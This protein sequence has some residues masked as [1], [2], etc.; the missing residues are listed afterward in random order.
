MSGG[1]AA[2]V[3]E[4]G[5]ASSNVKKEDKPPVPKEAKEAAGVPPAELPE[6]AR[7]IESYWIEEPFV[8]IDIAS[9]EEMGWAVGYFVREVKLN[10][11]EEKAYN[12]LVEILSKELSPPSDSSADATSH[13]LS[14]AR[15][16]IAKYRSF[17]G[18]G[19]KESER[20]VEY[21]VRRNLLGYGPVDP[22]VRDVNIEDISCDGLKRA[23]YVWHRKHESLFSNVMMTDAD[24]FDNFI[25][26]LAHL[27]GRHVSTAFPIVDAMLPG[28]H[29]LA[30]TYGREVSTGGSTFCIRKFREEPFSIVDLIQMGTLDLTM[31]AY[32]WLLLDLRLTLMIIGG[33]GAGKTSLLN[34]LTNLFKPGLKIVTVEETAELNIPHENWVQFVTRESYGLGAS[35]TGEVSLFELVRTSLRYRPDYIIVGEVRGDEAFVLFQAMASVSGDTPV[36]V[37]SDKGIELTE[38]RKLVDGYYADGE[39]RIGKPVRGLQVL[40]LEGRDATFKPVRYVLR[41]SADDIFKVRYVGG[42]VKAT[43]SHSVFMMDEETMRIEQRQVSGLKKGD[44]LV[45]FTSLRQTDQA[46]PVVDVIDV[47]GEGGSM[48]VTGIPIWLRNEM[49]IVNNP[50]PLGKYLE[51]ET[52]HS[53]KNH[54]QILKL[55]VPHGKKSIPAMVML[56]R[57]LAFTLGAYLADGCVKNANGKQLVFSFGRPEKDIFLNRVLSTIESRFGDKPYLED[58]GSYVLV[59]FS[60]AVLADLFEKMCGRRGG[61]KHVP[62]Q[63]WSAP[64]DVIRAFLDGMKA[65]A[66]RKTPRPNQV[67]IVQKDRRLVTELAWLA[68]IAGYDTRIRRETGGCWCLTFVSREGRKDALGT[69]LPVKALR[70]LYQKLRPAS[71]PY[72]YTYLL[73]SEKRVQRFCKRDKAKEV[74]DWVW[75]KRRV[76]PDDEAVELRA[77]IVDFIDGDATLLPTKSI[78][79]EKFSGYVYDLSVPGNEAFFGGANPVLLHNTGHGGISTIHADSLDYAMK[80]L[81]SPPMNVAETYLPVLNSACLIE[82]VPVP[83]R[84]GEL[85]F[86]RRVRFVWEVRRDGSS[87]TIS[88]WNPLDDTFECDAS[89]SSHLTDALARMGYSEDRLNEELAGREALLRWM[90]ERNVR[91]YKEVA[92]TISQYHAKLREK[93]AP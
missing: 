66:R 87:H 32:F 60:N 35:K 58:R 24:F 65:D 73:L 1:E 56:D 64:R 84:S 5:P 41:H 39:E 69:G 18:G 21:F 47:I 25:I 13:A 53:S 22:M 34:A 44:L 48:L 91:H 83:G 78:V 33:T 71:M 72:E 80:R 54:R 92:K 49:G 12:K 90:C 10:Q 40:T 11:P 74:L 70:R 37:R 27:A 51:I 61:E 36:L 14:E 38:V 26:K 50:M 93:T 68:R 42:D 28:R 17:L 9:V 62:P 16:L 30:A 23:I 67:S 8:K 15:R 52:H 77:R 88:E 63:M 89:R 19:S 20:K 6:A 55:T 3:K 76:E 45:S 46:I 29:R 75:K 81:T 2:E 79:K 85:P 43:G 82:R 59:E 4:E 57:D 86:G 7:L 31:A